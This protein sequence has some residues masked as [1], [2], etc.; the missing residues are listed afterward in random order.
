MVLVAMVIADDARDPAKGYLRTGR[1]RY[2]VPA[3]TVVR[4]VLLTA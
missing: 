3:R 1:D 2:P 4:S